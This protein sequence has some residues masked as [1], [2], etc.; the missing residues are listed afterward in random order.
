MPSKAC[1]QSTLSVLFRRQAAFT[2]AADVMHQQYCVRCKV[3]GCP[4]HDGA[5]IMPGKK[6][7]AGGLNPQ[8]CS[9]SCWMK[10]PAVAASAAQTAEAVETGP[11]GQ[12]SGAVHLA[13]MAA[14][15]EASKVEVPGQN[16]KPAQL[17]TATAAADD[18]QQASLQE[19][20]YQAGGSE[21]LPRAPQLSAYEEGLLQQG[22]DTFGS[23]ACKLALLLLDRT[24]SELQLLLQQRGLLEQQQE[25]HDQGT[26]E[27]Q[28]AAKRRKK[29][30]HDTLYNINSTNTLQSSLDGPEGRRSP[31]D[32]SMQLLLACLVAHSW[33]VRASKRYQSR[34]EQHV[35]M[36]ALLHYTVCMQRGG[37][38]TTA[39][40]HVEEQRWRSGEHHTQPPYQPCN[41]VGPCQKGSCSCIDNATFCEKFCACVSCQTQRDC[42]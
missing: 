16:P 26:A 14:V 24:C 36:S 20:R 13:G 33:H 22:L 37:R 7:Q 34:L 15:A 8:L 5:H 30:I 11:A 38:P 2:V 18:R 23:D 12:R 25:P 42:T 39:R 29:V 1:Q 28:P 31:C 19:Q 40:R 4:Q 17:P 3:Y 10:S 41:C 9:D 35:Y 21:G 27:E 6:P 32:S